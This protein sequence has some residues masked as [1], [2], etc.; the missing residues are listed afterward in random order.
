MALPGISNANEFYSAHYLESVLTND[1]KKVRERWDEEARAQVEADPSATGLG[2]GAAGRR[3]LPLP[4][5]RS[6]H[7]GLLAPKEIGHIHP[8]LSLTFKQATNLIGFGAASASVVCDFFVKSTGRED[9]YQETL[10]SLPIVGFTHGNFL[11]LSVRFLSLNCLTTHYAELWGECWD[12]TF[13]TQRWAKQDSRLPNSFFTNLTPAWQRD[14]ALRT[15]YAR[16]QALVEIDVLVP[17]ALGLTLDELITIYRVQF[18]V[19]QQY[20]R[21]S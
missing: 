5:A 15:D 1:I 14:C 12:D 21:G 2:C 16:R 6:G 11:P 10:Q 17:Q 4:A 9:L 18:P 19:M 3:D 20:E 7:G 8:I 13:R